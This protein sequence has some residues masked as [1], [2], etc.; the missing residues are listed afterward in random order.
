MKELHELGIPLAL[1]LSRASLSLTHYHTRQY[2]CNRAAT[3][4][5]SLLVAMLMHQYSY[6]YQS[7]SM[8]ASM[9]ATELL[10]C[11]FTAALLLLYCCFTDALLQ[12]RVHRLAITAALLL[13]Y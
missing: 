10:Y 12:N 6:E 8:R 11:C 7:I 5:S 9:P 1:A 13:L 3:A 2:A 4:P